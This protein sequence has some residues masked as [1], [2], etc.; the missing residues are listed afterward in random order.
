MQMN[1]I[2][3]KI[4]SLAGDEGLNLSELMQTSVQEG[5]EQAPGLREVR[6][7]TDRIQGA[8]EIVQER[9]EKNLVG[10]EAPII[11]VVYS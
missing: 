8:I 2:A 5:L 10:D 1:E 9:V 3:Q 4:D 7:R 11:K 6:Q